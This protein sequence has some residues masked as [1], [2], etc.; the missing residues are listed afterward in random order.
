MFKLVNPPKLQTDAIFWWY[1][2]AMCSVRSYLSNDHRIAKKTFLKL[3][4]EC[5]VTNSNA[6]NEPGETR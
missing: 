6:M 3:F 5:F 1:S 4:Q 2:D